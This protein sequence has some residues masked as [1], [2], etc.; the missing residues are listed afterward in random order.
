MPSRESHR[1]VGKFQGFE[2]LTANY[3]YCP[4]QFF[5]VCLPHGS[6]GVVRLVAYLLRRTLGWLDK[7]GQPLEQEIAVSFR[8]LIDEAGISRGA[9][10]QAVDDA[11]AMSLIECV[12]EGR[13]KRQGEPAQTAQYRLKWD[14]TNIYTKSVDEFDGF[15]AGEG[16]RSPVPNAFF[17]VIVPHESLAVVKVVGTVLRHT[18]GYQNQFGGRRSSAPLSY[19]RIQQ[20][21]ALRDRKTLAQAIRHARQAGYIECLE[22]GQFSHDPTERRTARYGVRWLQHATVAD[23]GSKTLPVMDR[24]KNPTRNGSE[25]P[26][27]D[28]FKKPTNRK[29]ILKDTNKQQVAAVESEVL[30]MLREAV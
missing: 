9:I 10:R 14:T 5:D 11:V 2:P 1:P 27:A 21:V 18:V 7:D 4:N 30:K 23:I 24:F 8:E 16:H 3:V 20:Y 29:T 12:R 15:F 13:A 19:N 26:P 25:S 22:E 17:D 6:R 28:R